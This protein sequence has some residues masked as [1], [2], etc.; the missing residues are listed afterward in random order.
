MIDALSAILLRGFW[1]QTAIAGTA[2]LTPPSP[3]DNA[4]PIK[5]SYYNRINSV[6]RLY[7]PVG[8]TLALRITT[9]KIPNTSQ[10]GCLGNYKYS[11]KT[12]S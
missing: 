8:N 1:G 9:R 11:G 2:R 7:P 4:L 12:V 10:L 3:M 5:L 6:I